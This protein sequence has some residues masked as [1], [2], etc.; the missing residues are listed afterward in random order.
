[1]IK[2]VVVVMAI[3]VTKGKI[4]TVFMITVLMNMAGY[5]VSKTVIIDTIVIVTGW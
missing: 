1:M 2:V 5:H 3:V 4:I